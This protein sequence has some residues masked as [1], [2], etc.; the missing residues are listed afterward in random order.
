MAS[1]KKATK[2]ELSRTDIEDKLRELCGKL[3]DANVF[4]N[5]P[6]AT[7]DLINDVLG[8]LEGLSDDVQTKA[9]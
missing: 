1:K 6:N 8:E 4:D 9:Y 3:E 7:D 2:Y 5:S